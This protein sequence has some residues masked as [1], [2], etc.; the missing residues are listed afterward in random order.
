MR[1]GGRGGTTETQSSSGKTQKLGEVPP[2]PRPALLLL[3]LL[4]PST[5]SL[6]QVILYSPLCQRGNPQSCRDLR[7]QGHGSS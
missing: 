1:C 2:R 4:A 7:Y 5:A 6:L 3:L